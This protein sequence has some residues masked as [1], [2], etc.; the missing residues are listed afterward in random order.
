MAASLVL[1]LKYTKKHSHGT[2]R[3]HQSSWFEAGGTARIQPFHFPC[4]LILAAKQYSSI[5][6]TILSQT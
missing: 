1:F 3:S 4:S 6:Q 2:K 5:A